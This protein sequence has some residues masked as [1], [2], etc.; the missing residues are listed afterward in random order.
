MLA[1]QIID[2]GSK[3]TILLQKQGLL[4]AVVWNPWAEKAKAMAD[5]GDDEYQVCATSARLG[6]EL[7]WT[8]TQHSGI[9]ALRFTWGITM[10][11][12]HGCPESSL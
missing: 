4:D 3:R 5:F 2:E 6:L 10:Q 11:E 12:H 1:L 8:I 7:F 9:F